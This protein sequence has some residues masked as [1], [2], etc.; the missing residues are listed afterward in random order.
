MAANL[1]GKAACGNA[2]EKALT[3]VVAIAEIW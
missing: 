1:A 3:I 2:N